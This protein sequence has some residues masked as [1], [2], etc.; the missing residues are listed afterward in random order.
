MY[1]VKRNFSSATNKGF[2]ADALPSWST[3]RSI[4]SLQDMLNILKTNTSYIRYTCNLELRRIIISISQLMVVLLV[5]HQHNKYSFKCIW[6]Q[7]HEYMSKSPKV[8]TNFYLI[9]DH[10]FFIRVKH[11]HG[12]KEVPADPSFSDFSA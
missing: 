12:W 8:K 6:S 1:K 5:L 9:I 3:T 2:Q 10:I 4:S 11:L 7:L